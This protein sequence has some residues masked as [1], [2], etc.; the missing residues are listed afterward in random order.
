MLWSIFVAGF[1]LTRLILPDCYEGDNISVLHFFVIYDVWAAVCEIP[2]LYLEGLPRTKQQLFTLLYN[3]ANNS[4][5]MRIA[6][7]PMFS[8]VPLGFMFGVLAQSIICLIFRLRLK[9][10]TI[11]VKFL[12]R[13]N[14]N[15]VKLTANT[16]AIHRN[17]RLAGSNDAAIQL[18][19]KTTID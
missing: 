8:R 19:K 3:H 10:E 17:S 1:I 13:N 16:M 2:K 18:S 12:S 9:E 11:V 14:N 7:L 6:T 15:I 4:I 5:G